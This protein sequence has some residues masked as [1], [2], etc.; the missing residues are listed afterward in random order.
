MLTMTR[1]EA[2]PYESM[3]EG[4][5]PHWDWE[6]IPEYLDSLDGA[7]QGRQL[8]PVHADGVADDLRDGPRGG[9]DPPG[10]R[11]RAQGDAAPAA[12]GHGRRPVRLLHP[13]P[14][15]R[16]RRRPT[17]TARRW[18]PTRCA[19]R[20]SSASAEV[21]RRARRGLHPDHPGHR[22]HQ[23]RPATFV[24]QLAEVSGRPI[25]HNV[26]AADPAQPRRRT[27]SRCDWLDECRDQGPA[28]LRP[29]RHRPRRASPS[30][31]STG[32]STTRQARRGGTLTTGTHDEKMAKMADPE[33]RE[34]LVAEAEAADTPS[35]ASIQA[36][37]GGPIRRASSCRASTGQHDL[38]TVRRALARRHR[39]GRGQAPHRGDARPVARRRPARSSSSARTRAPTPTS[40]PS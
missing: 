1:T 3:V 21:L 6:T 35:T 36:G 5:L 20:T 11:R 33:L 14:R 27:A 31:S 28:D 18:S 13:A 26:V 34:A 2:I 7:P 15:P 37:V 19:T 38:Q 16:T 22:R 9:Q 40:W 29:V 12:R 8:H 17:S 39:R 10:H 23:A 32:T 4:M 25:L 24:E 30:R